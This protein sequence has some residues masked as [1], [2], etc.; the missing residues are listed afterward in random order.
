MLVA[1]DFHLDRPLEVAICGAPGAED[2]KAMIRAVNEGFSPNKVAAFLPADAGDTGGAD[3]EKAVPLLAGK[4]AL[5]GK[6]T[7]YLCENFTCRE[8]LTDPD[9]VREALGPARGA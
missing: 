5:E 1:L 4:K 7:A 3:R 9:A 6:A 8:P 2:T